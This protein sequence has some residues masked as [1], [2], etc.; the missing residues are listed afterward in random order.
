M[1]LTRRP[2][3]WAG[4]RFPAFGASVLLVI[5]AAAVIWFFAFFVPDRR[6][7]AVDGWRRDL[8][9]RAEIRRDALQR[10]FSNGVAD[11]E[12]F[13]LYPAARQLLSPGS[14]GAP[15]GAAAADEQ[16]GHLQDLFNG[17]VRTHG[18]AGVV[19]WDARTNVAVK[20]RDLAVDDACAAPAR[21]VIASGAPALG[22]HLHEGVGPLLT[23]SAPVRSPDGGVLGVAVIAED[24]RKWLYPL[25]SQPLAGTTSGESLLVGRDG[26]DALYLSPLRGRPDSPLSFRRPLDDPEFAARK[27]LE[28]SE[29][30]GS[31][32]D[33]G[34]VRVLATGRLIPPSPWALVVKIDEAEAMADVNLE[35]R[36]TGLALVGALVALLFLVWGLWLKQESDKARAL[37]ESETRLATIL[38]QANDAII[39]ADPDGR[40]Q[41]LNRGCEE[42]YGYRLETLRGR[43]LADFNVGEQRETALA[44]LEEVLHL[45]RLVFESEHVRAD[46][47]RFPVEVSARAVEIGGE[48]LVVTV[49]RDITERKR[50]E[51]RILHLNRLLKTIS[52]IN[53]LIVHADDKKTLIGE[54]C[55]VLVEHGGFRMA[56]IGFVDP[57]SSRVVPEARAGDGLSYL[58]GVEIRTDD[59]PEA[60]GPTGTAIRTGARVVVSNV[61]T[62]PSVAPWRARML[63]NG[64]RAI[65]SFPLRIRGE[66]SGALTVYRSDLV[67]F[68][69]EETSLLDELAGD[70]GFALEVLEIRDENRRAEEA[71]GLSEERFRI[72][73][74]TSNDVIYEWNLKE[75]VDWFGDIDGL[76]GYGPGEFPRTLAGW[77]A[78]LH[79]EDRSAV[80]ASIQAHLEGRAPYIVE[81]RMFRRDGSVRWWSAR[82]AVARLPDGAPSR[83]VGTITD[84]TERK[85][86][87]EALRESESRFRQLSE[88]LPQLVWTC[89]PDGPCDY[90]NRQWIEFTGVPEAQQI[91]FGWL[92]QLHPDDRAPTVAS[93]EAAVAS[94]ANFRV[95]F[96]IR[97]HDGEYRWFYTRAVRLRDAEGHTVK[98]FG[99]NTDIT[100]RKQAE[101]EIRALNETLEGRVKERTRELEA[102]N[103]E[104]E[105]FSYSVSHDLRA[106]LRAMDGF[107]RILLED[108]ERQLD[109]E[110]KR[111]LGII[112]A[113]SVR[114]GNLIDDLL[115]FSRIGRQEMARTAVDMKAL[116]EEALRDLVAA[117]DGASITVGE[118]PRADADP[119]LMRQVWANLISN[120]LK[121]TGPKA[122]RAIEIA[123]RTEPN[124]VVYSV[125]DNG[126]GFDMTYANK[127]FGVFQRLHSAAEFEGTG[128]GLALVQ[129]I[130]HRHGGEVW[131]EGRVGEGATFSFSLPLTGGF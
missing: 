79:P 58:D 92:E 85:Q 1:T 84:I 37:A 33:Y 2:A 112:R 6:K 56:W 100:E 116:A 55:R 81:Y 8:S 82:G 9:T 77:S 36:R 32:V 10:F 114:M 38:D 103:R 75:R 91:G 21:D 63:E 117:D 72:A 68:S 129:R 12:S 19:L 26:S 126:V 24:P 78:I 98:W 34:G 14:A 95:E 59:T 31:F 35:I 69:A 88:S 115:S 42:I 25:L 27:A 53:Q 86:A 41:F 65:G 101:E 76:L 48:R 106:P 28:G 96:R 89:Q 121:F 102:T 66:V 73:A 74:E 54:A 5:F 15:A 113:N 70:L 124:R 7:A 13:A 40:I 4:A 43:V 29:A 94:G 105:A 108:H 107:S 93:W 52:E 109:T 118:L 67:P 17:Y 104:M 16:A 127:L 119:S 110:G 130:V 23:F 61:E 22:F 87:D 123:G 64:F 99:S 97:R 20:S 39:V 44:H 111:L 18:L 128:V 49:N 90:L 45:G 60:R 30:V 131:A 71:L 46:G 47:S 51:D 3:G 80:M 120:A 83:W 57:R 62:D 125:T 50:A 122:E 11:A